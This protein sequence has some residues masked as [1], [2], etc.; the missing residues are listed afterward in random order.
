[1]MTRDLKTSDFAVE[2]NMILEPWT[3]IIII[4]I[5]N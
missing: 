4:D 2:G 3:I 1:M 5:E